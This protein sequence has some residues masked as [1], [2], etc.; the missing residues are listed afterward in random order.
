M[1]LLGL[2]RTP[3]TL[4][5]ITWAPW[6]TGPTIPIP[7][8]PIRPTPPPPTPLVLTDEEAQNRQG[9]NEVHDWSLNDITLQD[10]AAQLQ[11]WMPCRLD[12][13]ALNDVGIS[14][15][16]VLGSL[17]GVKLS[18]PVVLHHLLANADMSWMVED[19]ELVLTTREQAEDRLRLLVLPVVD[20]IET[21]GFGE[22]G[23]DY[24]SLIELICVGRFARVL[25]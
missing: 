22:V 4:A 8:W 23:Y 9:V 16:L 5:H 10:L 1:A 19:G 3:P 20:L 7:A 11:V 17:R 12:I 25:G 6:A 24:E 21:P 14:P 2:F 13:D 18:T 15:S